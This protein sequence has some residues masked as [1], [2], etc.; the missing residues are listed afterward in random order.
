MHAVLPNL[1]GALSDANFSFY[2]V[3]LEGARYLT[4]QEGDFQLTRKI[5]RFSQTLI[6]K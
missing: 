5:L 1:Q 3:T 4:G 6:Q 2:N